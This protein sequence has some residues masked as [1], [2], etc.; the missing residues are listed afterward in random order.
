MSDICESHS[1]IGTSFSSTVT[2]KNVMLSLF[3]IFPLLCSRFV[4]KNPDEAHEGSPGGNNPL[5]SRR[6]GLGTPVPSHTGRD[7]DEATQ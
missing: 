3:I 2:E 1:S 7:T 4:A 5:R 6:A